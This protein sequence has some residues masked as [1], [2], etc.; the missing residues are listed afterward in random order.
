MERPFNS[1]V[2]TFNSCK[3][4]ICVILNNPYKYLQNKNSLSITS[5]PLPE[6]IYM[7]A[8]ETTGQIVLVIGVIIGCVWMN[9][10]M[11][12]A[13]FEHTYGYKYRKRKRHK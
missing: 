12:M 4:I 8:L 3:S 1:V 6:S 10:R 9:N 2:Q 7:E 5:L 13:N 11:R